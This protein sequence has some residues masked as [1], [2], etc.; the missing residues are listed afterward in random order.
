VLSEVRI[1]QGLTVLGALQLATGL[2]LVLVPGIFY[3]AVAAFGARNDHFLR[4]YGTYYL[5][6]GVALLLAAKRPSWR[7]PV[8]FLVT[9]Q[10]A[11]HTLNHLL[12]IGDSDPAWLGP[13]DFITLAGLTAVLGYFLHVTAKRQP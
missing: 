9:A 1:R 2:A 3:D 8:L 4:D 10:Y 12:D 13:F 5:A 7:V 11:L 6:S